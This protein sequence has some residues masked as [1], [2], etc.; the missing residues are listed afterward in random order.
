MYK[1]K[2]YNH[3]LISKDWYVFWKKNNLFEPDSKSKAKKFSIILPPPNITGHL[4]LGHA[5]DGTIQDVLIRYKRLCGYNVCW[6]PGTDHAGI[7]AQTKFDKVAKEKK[8]SFKNQTDYLN[9]LKTWVASQKQHIHN[10]WQQLG[11]ALSYQNESYTLDPNVNKLCNQVFIN[12]YNKDLIYRDYKLINWDIKLKT[13]ISDIEV[14]YKETKSKMYYFKYFIDGTKDFLTVATTRPETMFGDT[15]LVINPR[16]KRYKKYLNKYAINPVNN[17]KLLIIGDEYVDM[18]FGTGVMKC[19]PAHDFN[20]YELAKRHNIK[21]YHSIMNDDGTLNEYCVINKTSYQNI[22]RLQ[23]RDKIVNQLKTKGLLIKIEE[24]INNVGYSERTGEVVEPLLSKQWFVKMK[25]I[26]KQLQTK[27]VKQNELKFYPARF[28]KTLN[29]WL[30]NIN[31]W[32]ISRQLIWGHQIPAY[33]NKNK[34]YVG[35]KPKEGYVQDKDV[36]DTWFSSGL[37]PLVVTKYNIHGNMSSYYPIGVLVT[38]YDILF[39]WIARML[40]QC[41]DLSNHLPFKKILIHGLIRDELNRKMS[42]SLGNGIEPEEVIEQFGADALRLYLMFNTTMGEDV[43]FSMNKIAYMSNFLNKVWNIHNYLEQYDTKVKLS[44]IVYPLNKWIYWQFNQLV[45]KTTS[46]YEKFN[47]SI[48]V[49]D[50]INFIWDTYANCYLELINPLL[51]DRQYR[52]ETI[53]VSKYIFKNILIMLH[54]FAPFITENIYQI[55]FHNQISILNERIF[56]A[57]KCLLD[58]KANK[59]VAKLIPIVNKIRELRI[60]NHIKKDVNIN[61]NII[62]KNLINEQKFVVSFLNNYKIVVNKIDSKRI[63]SEWDI[64]NLDSSIIEYHNTFVS[65]TNELAKLNKQKL[66]LEAEIKR[67]EQ[68][69]ANKNFIAKAP[70][71]KVDIEKTKYKKYKEDYQF[72][73]NE[74]NKIKQ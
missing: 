57:D 19:T 49:K 61:I 21:D 70:K 67:S 24:H 8:L 50:L 74:I 62:D 64:I 35:L 31:D 44:K 59:L 34:I 38:A 3:K 45:V 2:P 23:A 15:N 40:F 27:L 58:N 42:K 36:L 41:N 51:N 48:L 29:T 14:V 13:A 37:W 43:R 73:I 60:K 30:D 33:Y 17:E 63:N 72:I 10:Q 66:Y 68:I 25:P 53:A 47:F 4:H 69:L 5:L 1:A 6:F 52:D 55:M 7:S 16:D 65:K 22:D 39:F 18:K 71:Q 12:L 11:F 32:C 46:L 26:V 54:P 9:Q 56:K 28:E 20:D